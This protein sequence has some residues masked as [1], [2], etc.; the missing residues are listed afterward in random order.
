MPCGRKCT[1]PKPHGK[2]SLRWK[3]SASGACFLAVQQLVATHPC[4]RHAQERRSMTAQYESLQRQVDWQRADAAKHAKAA[5]AAQQQLEALR[6]EMQL[7]QQAAADAE[8]QLRAELDVKE[9]DLAQSDARCAALQDTVATL[10]VRPRPY[11][12]LCTPT[13]RASCRQP[14][15]RWQHCRNAMPRSSRSWTRSAHRCAFT[16][17]RHHHDHPGGQH[18]GQQRSSHV[19][20]QVHQDSWAARRPAPGAA[21]D[22]Q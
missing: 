19:E 13:H 2:R 17:C 9:H 8:A 11:R 18:H 4:T 7:A 10:Q 6:A 12:C 22:N 5:S 14:R 21:P 1:L 3:L 15:T 20:K 16:Y